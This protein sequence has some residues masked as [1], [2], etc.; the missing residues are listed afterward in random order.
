MASISLVVTGKWRSR[1]PILLMPGHGAVTRPGAGRFVT[2]YQ[3]VANWLIANRYCALP[4]SEKPPELELELEPVDRQ[5][6]IDQNS[7]LQLIPP[8]EPVTSPTEPVPIENVRL[9]N[10]FMTTEPVEINSAISAISIKKAQELK[11]IEI[12]QW[13]DVVRILSKSAIESAIKWAQ[14]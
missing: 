7:N 5:V 1:P 11:Q 12:L 9:I 3:S 6:Y 10:F 13:S 8:I 14:V 2:S 4:E